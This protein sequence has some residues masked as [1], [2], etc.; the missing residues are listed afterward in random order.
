MST[1]LDPTAPALLE[2]LLNDLL[3]T[4]GEPR[5]QNIHCQTTGS[6]VILRGLASSIDVKQLAHS[7]V[8]SACGMREITNEIVVRDDRDAGLCEGWRSPQLV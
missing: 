1:L 7:V 6:E 5:L 4:C 8:R 2:D 3:Q